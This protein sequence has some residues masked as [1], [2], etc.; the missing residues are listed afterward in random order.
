[1]RSA[2]VPG[3][4]IQTGAL[5]NSIESDASPGSTLRVASVRTDAGY[6]KSTH[7]RSID[8]SAVGRDLAVRSVDRY[9]PKEAQVRYERGDEAV[10]RLIVAGPIENMGDDEGRGHWAISVRIGS[11]SED[12]HSIEVPESEEIVY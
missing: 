4:S 8:P 2:T 7:K 6:P 3:G 5:I 10:A 11:G 9:G 1:M 12:V